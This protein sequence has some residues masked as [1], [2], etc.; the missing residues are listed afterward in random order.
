MH[1]Q[2]K[3]VEIAKV[4]GGKDGE[5][6]EICAY[7]GNIG[8]DATTT[9]TTTTTMTRTRTQTRTRIRKDRKNTTTVELT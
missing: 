4:G 7:I 6:C 8:D 1:R 5:V 9:T 3:A 2:Q